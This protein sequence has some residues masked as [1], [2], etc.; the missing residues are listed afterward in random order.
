MMNILNVVTRI[1]PLSILDIGCGCGSFT[2]KLAPSCRQIAAIDISPSLIERCRKENQRANISYL[3]MDAKDIAYPDN[4]FDLVPKR[5]SLHHILP[6]RKAVD[7]MIRV[8]SKHI[9]I[10]E[11][12]DD[13]RS[14]AKKNTILAQQFFLEIQNEVGYAHFAHLEKLSL[15]EYIRQKHLSAEVHINESDKPVTFEEY[16]Q[17]F[18]FFAKKSSREDYWLDRLESF[19]KEMTGQTLCE[20]DLLFIAA[21]K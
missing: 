6:W 8:S 20:N 15:V 3:I 13:P 4:S 17:P 1:K 14:P 10:E 9:L 18:S 2:V 21:A 11:P 16:F 12:L 5:T 7:E 19:R